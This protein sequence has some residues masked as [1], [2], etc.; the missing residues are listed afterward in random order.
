MSGWILVGL[1]GLGPVVEAEEVE[2]DGW[3]ADEGELAD[4]GEQGDE[5]EQVD[6]GELED[7]GELGDE[8]DAESE[9]EPDAE[10]S[11]SPDATTPSDR[12]TE[13]VP[14]PAP[15]SD[16]IDLSQGI[17]GYHRPGEIL[18]REPNDGYRNIVVGSILVPLGTIATVTSA[19]GVWLTVPAHCTERLAGLGVTIDDP[20]SC[21]GVFTFNVIRTTYGALMLASGAVILSIGLVQR[22]RYRKWRLEHGMRARLTPTL[23]PTRGGAAAGLR[24]RF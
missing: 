5:G 23:G 22:Q 8:G 7:G 21:S 16:E 4:E 11:A 18:E 24:V 9:G 6:E 10:S 14:T 3:T 19:A 15:A 20:S 1:L 12:A 13:P 17:G 2:A